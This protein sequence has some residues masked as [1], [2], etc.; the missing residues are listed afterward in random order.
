MAHFMVEIDWN[1]ARRR[2][3]Y[4]QARQKAAL[5]VLLSTLYFTYEKFMHYP[6][7]ADFPKAE[8]LHLTNYQEKR[9]LG[10]S[11]HGP[12]IVKK[13]EAWPG[14]NGPGRYIFEK[15]RFTTPYLR[16]E[17][18]LDNWNYLLFGKDRIDAHDGKRSAS[19]TIVNAVNQLDY[20]LHRLRR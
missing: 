7:N 5:A 8:Q 13:F 4:R 6:Q 9:Y 19:M 17:S 20:R 11:T 2:W 14:W 16:N 3:W 18:Q 15:A 12:Y 1:Y 10:I